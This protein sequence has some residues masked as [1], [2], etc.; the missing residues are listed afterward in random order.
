[1]SE[2]LQSHELLE[3]RRIAAYLYKKEGRYQQSVD[4]SKADQLWQDAMQ[5][6]ADSKDQTVPLLCCLHE[7]T[8]HRLPKGCFNTLLRMIEKIALQHACIL[9]TTS[10][11]LT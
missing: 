8:N 9:A 10:F 2:R 3:F 1:M 11:D 5:T 7:L 6:A 4:L